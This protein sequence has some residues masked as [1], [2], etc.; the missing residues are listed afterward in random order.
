MQLQITLAGDVRV[1]STVVGGPPRVV[2]AALVLERPAGLS[3]DRLADIV[4]PDGPPKTWGSA[5]RTHVSRVRSVLASAVPGAGEIVVAGEPGYQLSL[6]PGVEVEV[7]LEMARQDLGA[8]RAALAAGDGPR[9]LAAAAAAV[10]RLRAPFLPGHPGDWADE[11]RAGLDDLLVGAH[12]AASQAALAV[13]DADRALAAADAAVARSPLRESAHRARLA[14][15]AAGGNR[16]EALR[17]YQ[18]LRRALADELGVDPSPET[19]A[20]Y[21]AL[22]GPPAGPSPSR[23]AVGRARRRRPRRSWAG[24]PSWPPWPRRGTRRWAAPVTSWW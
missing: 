5:L 22:L 4:W 2:L 9:A 6:P 15:L 8:A 12:E 13:G 11:V 19:E 21:V 23:T 24:R 18:H 14:A 7:D 20:A 1:G 10:D 3:R 16:A 17:A